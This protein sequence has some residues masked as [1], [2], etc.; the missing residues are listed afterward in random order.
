VYSTRMEA[1]VH[2]CTAKQ[3]ASCMS[4]C[5]YLVASQGPTAHHVQVHVPYPEH[6]VHSTGHQHNT[7][8]QYAPMEDCRFSNS[9]EEQQH[10]EVAGS[11]PQSTRLKLLMNQLK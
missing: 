8:G 11:R 1:G 7:A 3:S 9:W 4:A 10:L 2:E 6:M 5:T